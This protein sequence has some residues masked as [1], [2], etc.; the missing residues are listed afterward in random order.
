MSAVTIAAINGACAGA[1]FGWALACDLRIAASSARLNIA[2]LDVGVAGDM[3]IPWTLPRLVGAAKA[4]QLSF[5]PG[6]LTADEALGLGLVGWCVPDDELGS[7]VAEITDRLCGYDLSALR[8]LKANY[9]DAERMD[10]ASYV[11]LEST[12]Y[13]E[14]PSKA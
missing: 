13:L 5:L 8:T 11:A 12:R 7:K 10:F 4:R 9:L 3:G 6:K 2:F 1:A 14:A